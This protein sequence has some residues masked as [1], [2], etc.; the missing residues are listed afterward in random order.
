MG[1]SLWG[2]RWWEGTAAAGLWTRC[3]GQAGSWVEPPG[4]AFPSPVPCR[5]R[6][7]GLPGSASHRPLHLL[8]HRCSRT[9]GTNRLIF[10]HFPPFPPHGERRRKPGHFSWWSPRVPSM[11]W[12]C[13][14][15]N[16]P[17]RMRASPCP[18]CPPGPVAHR[19]PPS[20][21]C[22]QQKPPVWALNYPSCSQHPSC[23]CQSSLPSLLP[24]LR[25]Q[26]PRD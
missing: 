14:P 8:P 17:P 26:S 11:P 24:C 9:S 16:P 18:P 22:P 21:L 5:P 15:I 23:S 2:R 3:L 10:L 6:A 13:C 20:L 7:P 19:P 12:A 25:R 4:P 1:Q